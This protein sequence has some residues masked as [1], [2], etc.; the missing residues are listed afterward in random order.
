MLL[1]QIMLILLWFKTYHNA[2]VPLYKPI[3]G[4]IIVILL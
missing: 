2:L 4:L 1:S 3:G